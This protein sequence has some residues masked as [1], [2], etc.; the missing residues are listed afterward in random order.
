MKYIHKV[1]IVDDEITIGK[2]IAN[3]LKKMS[4]S[5]VYASSGE[6]ALYKIEKADTPFS[7][8]LA[9]QRMPNMK[10]YDLLEKMSQISP[11]TVRFLITGHA[12]VKA[13]IQAVN[14]GKIHKYIS[15]PW[16]DEQFIED[17]KAG[18]KQYELSLECGQLF[19]IAK[20]Q[21]SKLYA[22]NLDLKQSV[23]KEGKILT[24]LEEELLASQ[25]DYEKFFGKDKLSRHREVEK[26][27]D[28]YG[29]TD[30]KT[31]NELLSAAVVELYDR[32]QGIAFKKGFDISL[33]SL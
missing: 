32:F 5:Y 29:M 6:E 22:L 19:Q 3:I 16:V 31:R 14:Q 30:E 15:K 4:I 11:E 26:Y 8:I 25:R 1:L 12:D 33:N 9:D 13:V 27:L 21:N 24:V 28:D 18:L 7:L 23:A 10:G 2:I 20:E 17:I